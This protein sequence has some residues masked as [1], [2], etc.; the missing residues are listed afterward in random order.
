MYAFIREVVGGII[1]LA[2]LIAILFGVAMLSGCMSAK[3][4]YDKC[5]VGHCR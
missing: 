4:V 3:I 2:A 5:T 1:A